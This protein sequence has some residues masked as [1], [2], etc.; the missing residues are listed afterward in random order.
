ML[1]RHKTYRTGAHTRARSTSAPTKILDAAKKNM[2][3]KLIHPGAKRFRS[4]N[5]IYRK[6]LARA[7][8]SFFP[9]NRRRSS[10]RIMGSNTSRPQ[11]LSSRAER[12]RAGT[13]KLY[14]AENERHRYLVTQSSLIRAPQSPTV[15][16]AERAFR[17]ASD[18]EEDHQKSGIR[19]ASTLS[20]T[21]RYQE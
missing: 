5:P 20:R 2:R 1:T 16:S 4:E 12:R 17:S 15:A 18:R 3:R 9:R 13:E 10:I 8:E 6:R 14:S 21:D 19:D 7:T 11:S